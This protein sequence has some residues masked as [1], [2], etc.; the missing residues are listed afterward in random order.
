MK[1][2]FE[3][4]AFFENGEKHVG[5][6]EGTESA[7]K[8]MIEV[9]KLIIIKLVEKK[10]KIDKKKYNNND[11]ISLIEE[12]YYLTKSGMSLDKSI[13]LLI[14]TS[15]KEAQIRVLKNILID[16]KNGV[17]LSSSIV[18]SMKKENIELDPLSINFISTSEEIGKVH[19]GLEQLLKYL[20]FQK[21]I[22]RDIRQALSYPIFLLIMSVIVSF[23][24]F[25]LIIPR[26]SS[27]FTEKEF[28]KLPE[29]SRIILSLG[30]YLNENIIW[31]F[32]F[33]GVIIS[34]II[35]FIKKSNLK[36]ST[37]IYKIPKLSN[38]LIE[39]QL[40]ITYNALSTMLKGGIQLDKAVK[41]ISNMDLLPD[42]VDLFR[43]TF[44][45]V[46]K[47]QKISSIFTISKII[48]SS[49]IALIMVGENSSSLDKIFESLSLK[50]G[51]N[52]DTSIKKFLGLLEPLI[53]VFLGIFISIIVISIMMAVMSLTDIAA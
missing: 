27:I 14:Q 7:F 48:P 16:L 47:G 9:K 40:T 39:L 6:F 30:T 20:N 24:I 32:I 33:L 12:L 22:K 19:D 8:Q 36:I 37:I 23:L 10:K 28:E 17:Q 53:I 2:V 46:R 35:Y 3:Y 1:K 11:F 42:V 45:E 13:K 25:F 50:H 41:H 38:I 21:K 44:I 5:V 31:V 43:K 49:D 4:E 51:E 29:L 18:N 52:F 34:L 15:V 26:F